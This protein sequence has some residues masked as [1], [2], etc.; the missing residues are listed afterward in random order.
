MSL[1]RTIAPQ[2][3]S[4]DKIELKQAEKRSLDNGIPVYSLHADI[5]DVLKVELIFKAGFRHANKKGVA[6]FCTSL[7]TEGTKTKSSQE[8]S[9]LVAKYGGVLE[10]EMRRKSK[11]LTFLPCF[12]R[13]I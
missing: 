3:Q 5:Q 11:G 1:D 12:S 6:G 4:F 9:R 7:M 2:P 10:Y 8:I 13:T